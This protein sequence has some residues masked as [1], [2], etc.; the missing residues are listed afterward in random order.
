MSQKS[1]DRLSEKEARA[2]GISLSEADRKVLLALYACRLLTASQCERL[3]RMSQ[4]NTLRRLTRLYRNRFVD[5]RKWGPFYTYH[6]D[7]LGEE[8][9]VQ[10]T[11]LSLENVRPRFTSTFFLEHSLAVADVYIALSLAAEEAGLMLSW[12]N[13]AEAADHYEVSGRTRK[14]EPDAVIGLAGSNIGLLA[15]LEVDRATESWQKWS[16]KIRDYGDYF[17]SGRFAERWKAT[18]RVLVLVTTPDLRRLEALRNFISD[19]WQAGF[20]GKPVPIGFAVHEA[21]IGDRILEVPWESIEG[22]F[23]L[24][25]KEEAS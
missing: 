22:T 23:R 10:A 19:R 15:F 2:V 14:L 18:R 16:Q 21:A 20:L 9:I 8:Y 24:V 25:E 11:G 7:T 13:T 1:S 5:R 3:L 12:R 17:L 6:L 4:S